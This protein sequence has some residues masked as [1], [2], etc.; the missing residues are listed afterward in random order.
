MDN[1]QKDLDYQIMQQAISLSEQCPQVDTAYNVGCVVTIQDTSTPLTTGY[2]RELPGNTHAEQCAIIKLQGW[3]KG[4]KELIRRKADV[5]A[6]GKESVRALVMYTTMEPCSKRLS[7]NKPCVQTILE[8]N[9]ECTD[10]VVKYE[11]LQRSLVNGCTSSSGMN[12]SNS[13]SPL[14]RESWVSLQIERVVLAILE[15][16]KFVAECEGVRLLKASDSSVREV[17][18]VRGL[19]SEVM[20]VNSNVLNM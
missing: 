3:I 6:H 19:E 9:K 14:N 11:D 17:D 13:S 1:I 2:S 20:R 4:N 15:P 18:Y 5:V 10:M 12:A 8:F 7:G 16:S